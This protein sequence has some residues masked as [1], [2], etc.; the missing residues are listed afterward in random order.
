MTVT[1]LKARK[2]QEPIVCL[3]AYSAPIAHI[4]DRHVDLILVGDSAAMVV[5]GHENTLPISL[6]VMIAHAQAV[7]RGASMALVVVDLPFGCYESGPEQAFASAA[8]VLKETQAAAVKLEG[9]RNMAPTIEFLT[10]RGVP[11]MAHIGLLPQAVQAK[12]FRA[13]GRKR[14]EWLALKEDAQAVQ[15]AGAFCVVLE[16][17][18]EPL[19]AEITAQ[20]TIPTIGIGA[21]AACDGQ[22]LV[23]DDLLGLTMSGRTP[24]FVRRYADLNA[25]IEDAVRNYSADVKTRNF[26]E[27]AHTFSVTG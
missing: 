19:A 25:V 12:G 1:R 14:Q 26:P 20:L 3:T 17:M 5:H 7:G 6:D 8:R 9:G 2:R 16:G 10:A 27:I 11:V 13:T 23:I 21:S 24:R 18:A 22:I 4:L 15:D